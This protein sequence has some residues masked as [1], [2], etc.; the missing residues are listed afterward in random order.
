MKRQPPVGFQDRQPVGCENSDNDE[1][2]CPQDAG[3][4][5][6]FQDSDKDE[7]NAPPSYPDS[8]LGTPIGIQDCRWDRCGNREC[9]RYAKAKWPGFCSF[10]CAQICGAVT[11]EVVPKCALPWCTKFPKKKKLQWLPFCRYTCHLKY[12]DIREN[13]MAL[14]DDRLECPICPQTHFSNPGNKYGNKGFP[15]AVQWM[16]WHLC[17]FHKEEDEVAGICKL[18]VKHCIQHC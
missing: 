10:T 2:S 7:P 1:H 4:A 12:E 9:P 14:H 18:Y 11:E 13:V 17:D 5:V 16:A 3:A 8:T 6:P 15:W